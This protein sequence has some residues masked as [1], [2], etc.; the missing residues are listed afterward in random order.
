MMVGREVFLQFEREAV[1][2]GD[3]VILKVDQVS[4]VNSL[5]RQVLNRITFSINQGEI[6]GVAGVDGNGQ[7]ELADA[8]SGLLHTAHGTIRVKGRNLTHRPP[9]DFI[10]RGV[11]LVPADRHRVGLVLNFSVAENLVLKKSNDQPFASHGVLKPTRIRQNA[12]SA[13]EKYDI[14]VSGGNALARELSGGNQ[15]KVILAREFE[16]GP[17]LLVLVHPTRG[18]D[19]GATEYVRRQI[20]EQ[21]AK[22]IAILLI[23]TELE[24]ILS[25]SDRIAFMFRGEIMGIVPGG[26]EQ[27][28]RIGHMMC[29]EHLD[30][31]T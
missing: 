20:L 27:Y 6:L 11:C 12:E 29:G 4:A 18:L 25:L 1:E 15:Q 8:L 31:L 19:I 10:T 9:R 28:A 26:Y 21:R 13:I 17:S 22:G 5:G 24:E 16:A 14:R 30:R 3:H 7:Q 23:S 2:T